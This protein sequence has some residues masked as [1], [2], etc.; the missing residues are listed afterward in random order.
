[1][2]DFLVFIVSFFI[3]S[4]AGGSL[5]K[6]LTS[7][8]RLLKVSEYLMAFFLVS[9]ATSIPE[10]FVGISSAWKDI[11]AFSLGNVLGANIINATL[12]LGLVAILANGISI[13]RKFSRKTFLAAF[14]M[15]ILPLFFAWDGVIS[16]FDGFLSLAVFL[17]YLVYISRERE[18][19]SEV[20]NNASRLPAVFI[21]DFFA[22]LGAFVLALAAL[23]FSA[24]LLVNT[25]QKIIGMFSISA[26]VF[27]AL[28]VALGTTLPELI[29]GL[30]AVNLKHGAMSVGNSLGSI[31]F[32]ASF[33]VGVV[34]LIRP[35]EVVRDENFMLSAAFVFLALLFFSVFT[36]TK[37]RLEREEGV[38]LVLLYLV[39]FFSQY[40]LLI[41]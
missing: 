12:I 40:Y 31:V 14:G 2:L 26:F 38:F 24:F 5:V 39:F 11:P 37:S 13:E 8:A 19:F 9:F 1:M 33:V 3:L 4:W 17:L 22:G 35:I 15:G 41:K 10:L 27:G 34:S 21:K 30:K 32:N 29:F 23:L 16:R 36:S 25:G 7:L 28:L 18:Y 20:F 6:S